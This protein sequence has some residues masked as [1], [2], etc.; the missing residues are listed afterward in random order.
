MKCAVIMVRALSFCRSLGD[1]RGVINTLLK[2][3]A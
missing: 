2:S 1:G 3:F